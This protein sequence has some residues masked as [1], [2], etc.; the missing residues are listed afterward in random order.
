MKSPHLVISLLAL[1]FLAGCASISRTERNT[2]IQH[3]VSS[4]VC[5]RMVRGNPLSLSDIIELS[6]RQVPDSII[7]NYLDSTRVVYSLDKQSLTRLR[8]GKVSQGVINFLLDTPSL[9]AP[10]YV[11]YGPRPWYPYPAYYPYGPYYG[12][13][14]P[15]I[16]GGSSVIITGGRGRCR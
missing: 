7:V 15:Q 5:D 9:F 14:Y 1:V 2:L 3:N 13:C 10:R 12:P 8:Q 4:S 16:Y 6:Q 11:D